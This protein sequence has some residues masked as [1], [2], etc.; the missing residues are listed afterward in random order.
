MQYTLIRRGQARISNGRL[1][2]GSSKVFRTLF[3]VGHSA[4]FY[5]CILY[6]A[7]LLL[8]LADCALRGS[9]VLAAALFNRSFLLR[10][11]IER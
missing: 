6:D 3:R 10:Y 2:R 11:F 7:A 9:A 1:A 8:Q 5:V 4:N